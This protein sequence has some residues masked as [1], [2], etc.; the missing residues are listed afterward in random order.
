MWRVIRDRVEAGEPVDDLAPRKKFQATGPQ[1][2]AVWKEWVAIADEAEILAAYEDVQRVLLK[3]YPNMETMHCRSVEWRGPVAARFGKKSEIYRQAIYQLGLS[4]EESL[5]RRSRYMEAMRERSHRQQEI[6]SAGDVCAAIDECYSS[7][8]YAFNTIAVMLA[9]GLRMSEV[10]HIS[11]LSCGSDD[12]EVRIY[13]LAKGGR[14]RVSVRPLVRLRWPHVS[15][16]MRVIRRDARFVASS[17]A[18]INQ[19]MQAV[20]PGK[21]LTSHKCRYI[22]ASMAWQLYGDAPQQEWVRGMFG[23]DSADT[24]IT[25][26]LYTVGGCSAPTSADELPR[27]DE[28]YVE[29]ANS[30]GI[31]LPM[32]EKFRRLDLLA[33]DQATAAEYGW[34]AGVWRRWRREKQKGPA[35]RKKSLFDQPMCA[36]GVQRPIQVPVDAVVVGERLHGRGE[37]EVADLVEAHVAYVGIPEGRED[38]EGEPLADLADRG[39]LFGHECRHEALELPD[40]VAA[41]EEQLEV[42]MAGVRLRI[43]PLQPQRHSSLFHELG[44]AAKCYGQEKMREVDVLLAHGIDHQADSPVLAAVGADDDAEQQESSEKEQ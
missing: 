33:A 11:E 17:T 35:S 10:L 23:H 42:G 3:L 6:M 27:R 20:F 1:L 16:L 21:G 39:R 13:G 43:G 29:M 34:S 22:W 24:T 7:H 19:A 8:R 44:V 31:N 12:G 25:Y 5:A 36:D 32:A 14:E 41:D 38:V 40:V 30:A 18:Y 26:L 4:R 28:E 15:A 37:Q 9:T 2:L